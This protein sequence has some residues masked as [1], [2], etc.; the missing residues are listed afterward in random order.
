MK[1]V[2]LIL[3]TVLSLTIFSN[4]LTTSPVQAVGSVTWP[5]SDFNGNI[6][7]G[8]SKEGVYYDHC[9]AGTTGGYIGNGNYYCHE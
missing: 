4:V 9:P 3:L 6:E 7:H 1:R 5:Q 2:L 8:H